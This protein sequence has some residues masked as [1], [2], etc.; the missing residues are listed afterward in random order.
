[1]C[2]LSGGIIFAAIAQAANEDNVGGFA[3]SENIG[4]ISFNNSTIDGVAGG[5]GATNYGVGIDQNTGVMSGYAWSENIGWISFNAGDVEGCNGCTGNACL[6]T[7]ATEADGAGNHIITGWARVIA[8]VEAG[9][10]AGGWDGCLKF[11]DSYLDSHG[12]FMVG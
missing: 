6:P 10:N 8:A 12:D 5:G 11:K 9:S 2:C 4:W 3:W 1:L 7:V